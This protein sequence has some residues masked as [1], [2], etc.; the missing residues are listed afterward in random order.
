M[1]K[2]T[3]LLSLA[4]AVLTV[5]P[6]TQ[7]HAFSGKKAGKEIKNH[8]ANG[9][10]SVKQFSSDEHFVYLQIQLQQAADKAAVVRIT[11]DLGELLY[12]ER[13]TARTH[14]ML[15]KVNPGEISSL[16]LELTTA[17]GTQRKN[18]K[19]EMKTFSAAV[20]EEVSEK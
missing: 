12:S 11:D 10:I 6:G 19:L 5:A 1:K 20:V 3:Y 4:L 7:A 13:F 18:L 14:N 8:D 9:A 17:N 16:A 15:V 2:M